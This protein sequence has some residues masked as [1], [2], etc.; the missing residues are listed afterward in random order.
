[1]VKDTPATAEEITIEE[2]SEQ[3]IIQELRE[4]VRDLKIENEEL[5]K[6][7]E[8]EKEKY[9]KKRQSSLRIYSFIERW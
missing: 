3:Q 2:K 8:Q 7:L 9:N 4:Q 6:N 1:M 5:E